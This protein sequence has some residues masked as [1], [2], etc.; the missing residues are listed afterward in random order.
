MDKIRQKIFERLPYCGQ[1]KDSA[2]NLT[3]LD[4]FE[5]FKFLQ[6]K[7]TLLNVFTYKYVNQSKSTF[8][9]GSHS[10]GLHVINSKDSGLATPEN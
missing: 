3:Q 10:F 7:T 5:L 6:S 1:C 8:V 9:G 4:L 2:E